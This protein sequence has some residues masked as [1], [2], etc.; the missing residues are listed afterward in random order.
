MAKKLISKRLRNKRSFLFI[1][2]LLKRV[3]DNLVLGNGILVIWLS[4]DVFWLNNILD[5]VEVTSEKVRTS[6]SLQ[7]CCTN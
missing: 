6:F 7:N 4:L 1:N 2:P 3:N 5:N